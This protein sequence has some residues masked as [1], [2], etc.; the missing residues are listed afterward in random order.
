M[1]AA[2]LVESMDEE[3]EAVGK[4][5]NDVFLFPLIFRMYIREY[6]FDSLPLFKRKFHLIEF[7]ELC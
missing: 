2:E 5:D 7:H 4:S 1:E 6:V 3:L